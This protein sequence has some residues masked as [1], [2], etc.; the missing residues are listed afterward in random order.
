MSGTSSS[1]VAQPQTR[2][3]LIDNYDSFTYNLVQMFEVAGA[4]VTVV[5]NDLLSADAL[6]TA[7]HLVV[8]PGPGR[9]EAAGQS[10]DFI[11]AATGRIPV[12]GVCLG[13]Q[14]LAVAGSVAVGPAKRLMHGKTSQLQHDGRGLFRGLPNPLQVGRYHSLAV[15]EPAE[16]SGLVVTARTEDGEI[17]AMERPGVAAFGVQFHPESILTPEGLRIIENFLEARVGE[18]A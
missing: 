13:H 11:Q 15:S 7:T 17:M 8:S 9:P 18:P 16:A 2:V 14:A 1:P 12:L 4:E 5:R 6:E 3:L 10:V